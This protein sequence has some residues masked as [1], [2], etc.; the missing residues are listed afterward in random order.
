[1]LPFFMPRLLIKM[2]ILARQKLKEGGLSPAYVAATAGG[3][4]FSNTGAEFL[5]VKNGHTAAQTVTINNVSSIVNDSHYGKL[6]KSNVSVSIPAG[7]SL[8][9][10]PFPRGGFGYTAEVSYSG[11]TALTVAIMTN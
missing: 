11:V 5:H 9:I 8:F 4:S 1:M 3:D 6:T 2:A 7:E 10:G